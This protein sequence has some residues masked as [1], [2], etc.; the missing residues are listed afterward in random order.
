MKKINFIARTPE[1]VQKS[2]R[3][4]ALANYAMAEY[5]NIVREKSLAEKI[6]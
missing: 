5:N 3:D 4:F 2:K 1:S 6:K